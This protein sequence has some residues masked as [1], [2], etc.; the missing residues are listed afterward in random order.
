MHRVPS[1]PFACEQR[2]L[3]L[4]HVQRETVDDPL[5]R[6]FSLTLNR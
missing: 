2:R 6:M 4:T 1:E 5:E 3:E